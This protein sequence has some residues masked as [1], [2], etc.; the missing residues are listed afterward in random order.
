MALIFFLKIWQKQK[1]HLDSRQQQLLLHSICD[2]V[3]VHQRSTSSQ[4][5]STK[6][7]LD[8]ATV[9]AQVGVGQGRQ[10]VE[11]SLNLMVLKSI[12]FKK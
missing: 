2:Q 6:I 12:L 3:T 11:T 1:H 10:G 7:Q 9:P 5:L 8:Q 4:L